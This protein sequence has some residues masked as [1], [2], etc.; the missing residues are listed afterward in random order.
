MDSINK[1]IELVDKFQNILDKKN[2][3]INKDIFLTYDDI[4]RNDNLSKYIAVKSNN[5]IISNFKILNEDDF[6]N[7][8]IND[9]EEN[10][11]FNFSKIFSIKNNPIN[12]YKKHQISPIFYEG[13]KQNKDIM[14]IN[15]NKSLNLIK[16]Q[17]PFEL[18]FISSK[19]I[20]TIFE[21]NTNYFKKEIENDDKESYFNYAETS[22]RNDHTMLEKDSN[23]CLEI[24]IILFVLMVVLVF[25]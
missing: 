2:N 7:S 13:N 20:N 9:F 6:T 1:E 19:R 17:N 23:S 3:E 16:N 10:S 14:N 21:K 24:L 4:I 25:L 12:N 8:N 18:D 22:A 15:Y 5:G 11:I